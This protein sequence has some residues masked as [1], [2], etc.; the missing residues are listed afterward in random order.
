M[1]L[2][3]KATEAPIFPQ[4]TWNPSEVLGP[5][6]A[7]PELCSY[8]EPYTKETHY[9]SLFRVYGHH[10]VRW[11]PFTRTSTLITHLDNSLKGQKENVRTVQSMENNQWKK[12][13][14]LPITYC[15]TAIASESSWLLFKWKE[16]Y[17]HILQTLLRLCNLASK[18]AS[19]YAKG[20]TQ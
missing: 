10:G 17:T 18:C 9:L 15:H 13:F 2:A 16:I 12:N 3:C 19:F 20:L 7:H 1:W 4:Q 5:T 14:P 6:K 8:P 11:V